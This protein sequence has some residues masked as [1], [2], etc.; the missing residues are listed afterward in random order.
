MERIFPCL[1][2]YLIDLEQYFRALFCGFVDVFQR[3]KNLQVI[4]IVS[5]KRVCLIG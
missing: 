2:S 5:T 4:A 3:K 1:I